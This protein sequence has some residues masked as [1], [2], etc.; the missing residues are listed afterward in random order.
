MATERREHGN[1]GEDFAATVLKEKGYEIVARNF[2]TKL[3]EIDIIARSGRILAF[4]E[5]KSRADDCMYA[6][7]LAVTPEKQKKICKAAMLYCMKNGF[8]CQPRFDVFEVIYSKNDYKV[9]SYTH[10]E[11]AFGTEAVNGFF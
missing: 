7:R 3:G 5:V 4:V 6:P 11:N 9:K 2:T 1:M 8:N 10:I